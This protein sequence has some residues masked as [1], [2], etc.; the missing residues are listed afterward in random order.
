[1]D[2]KQ[3]IQEQIKVAMK[4]QQSVVLGALRMLLSEIKKREIDKKGALEEAEILRTIS[5]LIKQR[6]ESS[7]AFEKGGRPEMAA[8]ERAEI[9]A[10]EG[11][12]PAQLSS[13]ELGKIV[14]AAIVECGAT[15]ANDIGKVMKAAIAKAAGRADGKAI[16]E[17][18][19][20]KLA[21]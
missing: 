3:K 4:S 6:Q 7:E 16:N 17:L 13:E 1:M 8:Q 21:K 15:S 2:L 10:L 5:T 20:A 11:F 12:L 19:R 18:V 14:D 9:A